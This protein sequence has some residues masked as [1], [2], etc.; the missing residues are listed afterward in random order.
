MATTRERERVWTP[1]LQLRTTTAMPST[2]KAV[3]SDASGM[4]VAQV[5]PYKSRRTFWPSPVRHLPLT[6]DDTLS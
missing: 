6:F 5:F 2:G 4:R 1:N 3:R